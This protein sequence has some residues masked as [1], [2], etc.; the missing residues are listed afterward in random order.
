MAEAIEKKKENMRALLV[1][2]GTRSLQILTLT[3][4]VDVIL[5]RLDSLE[6]AIEMANAQQRNLSGQ[7]EAGLYVRLWYML[8]L[9]PSPSSMSLTIFD[10]ASVLQDVEEARQQ[11]LGRYRGIRSLI[12]VIYQRL[13]ELEIRIHDRL[14]PADGKDIYANLEDM[15][16]VYS[17]LLIPR[18]TSQNL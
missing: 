1:S 9:G 5:R 11:A 2:E 18:H 17:L 16:Q 10:F 15:K 13:N 4:D 6:M 14:D 7:I 3:I 8:Y 12:N